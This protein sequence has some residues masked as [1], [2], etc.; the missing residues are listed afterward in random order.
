MEGD[1]ITLCLAYLLALGEVLYLRFRVVVW[2]ISLVTMFLR[3]GFPSFTKHI[4]QQDLKLLPRLLEYE[5]VFSKMES[6]QNLIFSCISYPRESSSNRSFTIRIF[7]LNIF[8]EGDMAVH[9]FFIFTSLF[10]L[11]P[12][13]QTVFIQNLGRTRRKST[14]NIYRTFVIYI[15]KTVAVCM[16]TQRNTS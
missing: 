7:T 16:C 11:C 8:R 9:I 13:L 1:F 5:Y 15:Y 12:I 2:D 10:L 4:Q 6:Q 3:A 14:P